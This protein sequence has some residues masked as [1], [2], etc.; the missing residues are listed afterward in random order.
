MTKRD[1][2][3]RKEEI[4]RYDKLIEDNNA[5]LKTYN[6]LSAKEEWEMMHTPDGDEDEWAN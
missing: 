1:D 3:E 5:M 4:N 6:K 2:K